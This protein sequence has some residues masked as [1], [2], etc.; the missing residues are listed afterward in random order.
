MT[1]VV[2]SRR[3]GMK[4]RAM[5]MIIAISEAGKWIH[6]KGVMYHSRAKVKSKGFVV[7]VS[8]IVSS[9]IKSSR[10]TIFPAWANESQ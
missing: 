10:R 2:S 3:V 9:S 5:E 6:F 8:T 1:R 7:E 4:R